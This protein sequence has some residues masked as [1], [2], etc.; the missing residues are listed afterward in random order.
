[1]GNDHPEQPARLDAI[2][3]QLISSGLDFVVRH[4]D[5]PLATREQLLRVHDAG[6]VD[7]LFEQSPGEGQVEIADDTFFMQHTL[8]AALRAAGAVVHGVEL[9]IQQE[10]GAVFCAVRPPGHHAE[11]NRTMGFCFFNN[12]AIGAAHAM[13]KYGI[14]R[15]AIADFDVHHGNGTENIFKDDSRVLFC[16][17]FQHPFFPYTEYETKLPSIVNTPLCA[18]ADG[19]EFRQQIEAHWLPALEKFKPQLILISA[20][21]DAHLEDEMSH[22]RLRE[23]DYAWVTAQLKGIAERYASGRI[24]SSL[25][26]G[27]APGAL[28]RSV[29]AHIDALLGR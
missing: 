11:R 4:H 28:G 1:M 6:H 16:S 24:V 17:S 20:G 5:A 27:Y 9:V 22:L 15:I 8:T 26:G 19:R 2:Q 25:E 14:E 12:I 3:N 21:F 18:G 7:K 29:A 10:A 13:D 23:A